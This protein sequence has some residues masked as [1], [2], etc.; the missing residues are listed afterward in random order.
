MTSAAGKLSNMFMLSAEMGARTSLY[1]ALE[2]GLS[3][4]EYSGLEINKFSSS[5]EIKTVIIRS[6]VIRNFLFISVQNK[7]IVWPE[8]ASKFTHK[9]IYK[10]SKVG[11]IFLPNFSA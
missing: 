11:H 1:C 9:I 7:E 10:M 8:N 2:P 5:L 6:G 4:P 3:Q